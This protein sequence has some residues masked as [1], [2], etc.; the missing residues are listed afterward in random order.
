MT[1]VRIDTRRVLH[2]DFLGVGV[3][4]IPV[5]L[6]PANRAHGYTEAHW[7]VDRDRIARLRPAVARVWF[8]TDWIET[9]P[10]GYDAESPAM[11]ALYPYLDAL[12][13]AGTEVVLNVGWKVGRAIQPW[14]ALPGTE[15][16]ISA[17]ADLD[18]FAALASHLV[19]E[20]VATRGYANVRFLAFY[21]EP[22]GDWDFD[23]P[24]DQQA[25]YAAMVRAVHDR[26]VADGRRGL[27]GLW[28]PEEVDAPEWTARMD[29]LAGDVFD[30][31]SFHVYGGD[32]DSLAGE[33]A[34]RRDVAS[35]HP[36]VL[37]EF[38]FPGEGDSGFAGGYT[39]HV[40]TA[41]AEGLRAALVWQLNGV[42]T[43]DPDESVDTNGAYTLWDSSAIADA[44]RPRYYEVG[45]LTRFVPR[46]SDVL[47]TATDSPAVRAAAFR[48]PDGE[49]AIVV[50]SAGGDGADG[51][52]VEVDGARLPRMR[53]LTHTDAVA[54]DPAALLPRP[55][56][57]FE[58]GAALGH[59]AGPGRVVAVYTSAPEVPQAAVEPARAE[60]SAGQ[61]LAFHAELFGADLPGDAGAIDWS[62]P[63]GPHGI[64]TGPIDG[65]PIDTGATDT[66]A[67]GADGVFRAPRVDAPVSLAIRAAAAADP[68]RTGAAIV[69]IR[70]V[71][72]TRVLLVGA[73]FW[74]GYQLDAWLQ[75]GAVHCVG[76]CDPD[77]GAAALAARCGAPVFATLDAAIAALGPDAID[78]V[79]IVTPPSTHRALIERAV[80]AGIPVACQKPLADDLDDVRAIGALAAAAP[81]P[82][83]VHENWRWQRP[84]RALA[85]ELPSIGEPFRGLIRYNSSFPVFANQPA[86]R[87]EPR[88][89]LLDMGPHLFDVARFLLGDPSEVYARTAS[90]APGI[91]GEDVATVVLGYASGLTVTVELSYAS[92]GIADRFPETLITIEGDAGT[93]ELGPDHTVTRT[94]AAGRVTRRHPPGRYAWSVDPYTLVQDAIVACNG[95]LAAAAAGLTAAETPAADNARTLELV[96]AAYESARTGAPVAVSPEA[97]GS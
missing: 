82:V 29:E 80:A 22:N 57:R 2:R 83:L 25:Y 78:L 48:G 12:R 95:H 65:A 31:Y 49:I 23:A 70:A 61:T 21:N 76:V 68:E 19:G 14:F 11:R 97:V 81:T 7:E 67:I 47:A 93:V 56:A 63:A 75:T 34:A 16:R 59:T 55:V 38:G 53:L 52:R 13:D 8:Q 28:G 69:R 88:F 74:A 66:G 91:A 43:E 60:L 77:P 87:R 40:M 54:P 73:G 41:A 44:P 10:G 85:A 45:L 50:E 15:A 35:G 58:P 5:A 32:H 6:M 72:V 79:D 84:I 36:L 37:S 62:V 33:I 89:I 18:G 20:L 42:W 27:V 86:L 94:T 30:A 71:P 51:I 26:L 4:V 90:V 64:D 3:D 1:T 96:F 9:S 92:R 39:G 24:G 17:P 46:H